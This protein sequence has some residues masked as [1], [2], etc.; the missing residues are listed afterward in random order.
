MTA[1]GTVVVTADGA[2]AL[3]AVPTAAVT[4]TIIDVDISLRWEL[5]PVITG[6]VALPLPP[7][8]LRQLLEPAQLPPPDVASHVLPAS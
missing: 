5:P 2:A 3:L 4:S 7:T 1:R 8:L 6:E